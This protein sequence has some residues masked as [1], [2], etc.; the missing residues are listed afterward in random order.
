MRDPRRWWIALL[1]LPLTA[2]LAGAQNKVATKEITLKSGDE[3]IKGFLVQPEG[4]GPFPG[5]VMIQ[6][7]WGL[8]DWIKQNAERMASKGYVVLAPD[9]YR[10]KVTDD[11]KMASQLLKGLPKDRA[12]RDLKAAVSALEGM[13]NVDKNRIG[14]IG[15]CMGGGLSLQLALNDSRVKSLV[16]CYGAVVTDADKLK[17]LSAKVL[18]IFGEDD[19]GIPSKNVRAF[20]D[21]LKSAGRSVEQI[22]IYKGAGHGFMRANNGP[23]PNPEYRETQGRDAWQQIE[24]FFAKSLQ[25]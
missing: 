16:I 2:N 18:G 14:S 17:S 1:L 5:I 13:P 8:N 9:L 10:G 20:E 15:W 11:P 12:L 21:A 22:H 24:A 6:E 23:R 4:K 19:K 25:K 7:W 3:D